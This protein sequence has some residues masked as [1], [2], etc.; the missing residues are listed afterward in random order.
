MQPVSIIM[1]VWNAFE[2][3]KLCLPTLISNTSYP[4][5]L[6]II[7]NGSEPHVVDF[8]RTVAQSDE[9]VSLIENN[10]NPGPGRANRLGFLKAK[11][12]LICLIDSDVL[13]PEGWLERLVSAFTRNRSLSLLAPM[14]YHSALKYQFG[15]VDSR[16]AWF[17]AKRRRADSAP[18][19]QF[20]EYSRGLSITEYDR[21]MCGS[22]ESDIV[23]LRAPPE[24]TSSC[25]ILVNAD[26][27]QTAGGIA[28]PD[29][30][31][32]GS[33]DVDLCWRL[34]E[35]G[36][37]VAKTNTVYVHHFHNSSLIDNGL[38]VND[39][40]EAAN[41]IL[42]RKWKGKLLSMILENCRDEHELLFYLGSHFIFDPLAKN[43]TLLEDLR[44]L[45]PD[46][47]VPRKIIWSPVI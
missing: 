23:E 19:E 9:R 7:D 39:A 27:V 28:D 2:H 1:K 25:C 10:Q 15:G 21:L 11:F 46:I 13:V 17:A 45:C 35:L 22:T 24:F 40:L 36:G 29:F 5:E 44:A 12:K 34:G 42:Y 38:N 33:E 31:S 16:S 47:E 30:R 14:K 43:T 3:V 41:R 26:D 18:L 6:L 8:L 32:Y 37:L 4:Y 20:H